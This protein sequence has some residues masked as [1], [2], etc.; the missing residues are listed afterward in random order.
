ML[1]F[2]RFL[3]IIQKNHCLY[4]CLKVFL[5]CFSPVVSAFQILYWGLQYI[6][7]LFLY[8]VRDRYQISIFYTRIWHLP[9]T[10]YYHHFLR[11]LSCL[12]WILLAPLSIISDSDSW[13]YFWD[14]Y[15]IGRV[16]LSTTLFWSLWICSIC[17]MCWTLLLWCLQILFFVQ[18][19]LAIWSLTIPCEF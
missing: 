7:S 13:D 1:L 16:P 2:S 10:L 17:S 14:L 6:L 12:P 18:N 15:H 19:C 11:R 4:Q 9:T 3:T 5:L 8:K